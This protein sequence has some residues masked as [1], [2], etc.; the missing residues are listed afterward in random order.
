[1]NAKYIG[2]QFT[3]DDA[4]PLVNVETDFGTNT[5]VYDP[6]HH[7]MSMA[8]KVRLRHRLD[9]NDVPDYIRG[10]LIERYG[11]KEIEYIAQERYF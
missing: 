7:C 8:D 4:L 3:L 11:L 9:G 5:V 1:M 10:R 6:E 2:I